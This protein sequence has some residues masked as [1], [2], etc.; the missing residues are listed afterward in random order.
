MR[1]QTIS[2]LTGLGI[3]LVVIG[4][5]DGVM[6][7]QLEQIA[8]NNP[9]YNLYMQAIELIYFFHM[10]LFFFLSGFLY[11]YSGSNEKAS[12]KTFTIK[13]AF[14]LLLP[15]VA[16]SSIAYPLKVVM[17]SFALRPL[18][19]SFQ[20][21]ADT[22]LYP[23]HNTI[24]FFWFLPTLFLMF[25]ISKLLLSRKET[26]VDISIMLVS[27]LTYFYTSHENVEGA[28]AFLNIGG[29]LHN[30][31]FFF[32]GFVTYKYTPNLISN[33]RHTLLLVLLFGT[34]FAMFKNGIENDFISLLLAVSGIFSSCFIVNFLPKTPLLALSKHSFQ[35][36]LL[37]WFP[38]I[39]SRIVF[40][41]LY[42]IN[43][44]LSVYASIIL[45]ILVPTFITIVIQKLNIR[46]LKSIVGL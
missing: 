25:V 36:Y 28:L 27:T 11:L 32:I 30:Y 1:N 31:L 23:W 44:G 29:V 33:K 46:T 35:I 19:W 24:I 20:S 17:S 40:G 6:P 26:I 37:S 4:H 22:L 34:T 45:G 15:Y 9:L 43:I 39:A 5:A 21:Y 8:A 7:D 13:K 42:F 2:Y 38:Q 12:L 10:P 18:T 41:K 14:R 3:L 16:I